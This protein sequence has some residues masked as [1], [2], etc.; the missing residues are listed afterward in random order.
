MSSCTAR[1][2]APKN[3]S[4]LPL[5][6]SPMRPSFNGFAGDCSFCRPYHLRKS[7]RLQRLIDGKID[8]M[9]VR[10]HRT[11]RLQA[12]FAANAVRA[13]RHRNRPFECADDLSHRY[14][15]RLS[16]RLKPPLMPRCNFSNPCRA[17]S[18]RILLTTGSGSRALGGDIPGI[19]IGCALSRKAGQNYES[20]ISQLRNPEHGRLSLQY[21]TNLVLYPTAV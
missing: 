5:L 10:A 14:L 7:N 3:R 19:A 1:N 20:V 11:A 8:Q 18:F 2:A 12:A 4:G 15:L 16:A 13:F 9:P 21:R 17:S 6:K